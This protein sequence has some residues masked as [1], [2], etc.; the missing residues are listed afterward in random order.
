MYKIIFF[1]L[2]IFTL[3]VFLIKSVIKNKIEPIEPKLD[4]FCFWLYQKDQKYQ[5]F[6]HLRLLQQMVLQDVAFLSTE[7]KN[8]C[9][10]LTIGKFN[11]VLHLYKIVKRQS[12]YYLIPIHF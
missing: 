9:T 11:I 6:F 5:L 1:F 2:R 8:I 10:F 7:K 4:L 12:C 3:L